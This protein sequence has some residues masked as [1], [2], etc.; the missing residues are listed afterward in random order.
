LGM[1]LRDVGDA[2]P[3]MNPKF[4]QKPP[5]LVAAHWAPPLVGLLVPCSDALLM[6]TSSLVGSFTRKILCV[7]GRG[8]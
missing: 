5:V 8:R 4:I 6:L 1:G 3:P 7:Q 2:L